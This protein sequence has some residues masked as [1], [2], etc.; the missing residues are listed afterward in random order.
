[1]V[2]GPQEK[3][4]SRAKSLSMGWTHPHCVPHLRRRRILNEGFDH[5]TDRPQCRSRQ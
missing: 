3:V 5:W 4:T 2:Y 1:M